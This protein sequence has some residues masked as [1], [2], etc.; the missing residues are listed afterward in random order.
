MK[1]NFYLKLF[2]IV[3]SFFLCITGVSA[4]ECTTQELRELKQLAKKVEIGY[5]FDEKNKYFRVS[6]H[7]LKEGLETSVGYDNYTYTTKN[8]GN[9]RLNST[10]FSGY[11]FKLNIYA[12]GKTNCKDELL[13]TV[14]KTLPVYNIFST[15]KECKGFQ[16]EQICRKWYNY[17]EISED[18]FIEKITNLKKERNNKKESL[19]D[20]IINFFVE[21]WYLFASAVLIIGMVFAVKIIINNKNKKIDL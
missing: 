15:R 4:K 16:T 19:F 18:E 2:F 17:T 21:F 14:K 9:F 1:R 20:I 13:Y 8:K 5:E 6:I 10:Y 7:N 3:C 12:N 11:E